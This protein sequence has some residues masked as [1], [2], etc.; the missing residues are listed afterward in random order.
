MKKRNLA[1]VVNEEEDNERNNST[2]NKKKKQSLLDNFVNPSATISSSSTA[3]SPTTTAGPKPL[4]VI[5][6]G[7]GGSL[8]KSFKEKILPQLSRHFQT[9]TREGKWKNWNLTNPDTVDSVLS[10][11]PVSSSSEPWYILGHSFGCRVILSMIVNNSF[12]VPPA[13]V[14]LTSYPMY[15]E[16]VSPERVEL[17][18][19]VP[20]GHQILCLSGDKDEF[21]LR[22]SQKSAQEIYEEI[23][24]GMKCKDSVTLHLL[25]KAGHGLS[26][27]GKKNEEDLVNSVVRYTKA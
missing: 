9:R 8:S 23:I 22:G 25:P 21:L 12:P 18:Q 15:G 20:Q 14:I 10:H 13:K 24:T 16:K 11:C 2:P 26:E 7:A 19:S 6:P 5:L 1:A 4:L 17:L 27:G 3:K